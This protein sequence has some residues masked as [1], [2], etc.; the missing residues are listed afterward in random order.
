MIRPIATFVMILT[1]AG[2]SAIPASADDKATASRERG[3]IANEPYLVLAR[4]Y[5]D[6][7]DN[8]ARAM[9]RQTSNTGSVSADFARVA[10]SEMRRSYNAMKQ[11]HQRY[12]QTMNAEKSARLSE[13]MQ[14]RVAHEA[15]LNTR[16][17]ALEREVQSAAPDAKRVTT[18]AADVRSHLDFMSKR[19]DDDKRSGPTEKS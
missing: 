2:V 7:I 16:L 14:R 19:K 15:E 9:H 3:M 13:M 8:F 6:N 5:S 11:Q 12:M 17:T 18:L 10:V 1:L 4:A